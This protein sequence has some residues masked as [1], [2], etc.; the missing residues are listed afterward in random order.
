M[1]LIERAALERALKRAQE[2]VSQCELRL[3]HAQLKGTRNKTEDADQV[4]KLTLEF[5]EAK[6]KETKLSLDLDHIDV[7]KIGKELP[8][9]P[10]E[11]NRLTQRCEEL[12]TLIEFHLAYMTGNPLGE[13]MAQLEAERDEYIAMQKQCERMNNPINFLVAIANMVTS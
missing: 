4:A 6:Y 7:D 11:R 1:L 9:S 3:C 13:D 5:Q 10:E 2:R 8:T 12:A